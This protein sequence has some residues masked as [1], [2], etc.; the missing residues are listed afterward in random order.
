MF[1]EA[2]KVD[3]SLS[4]VEL[5]KNAQNTISLLKVLFEDFGEAMTWYEQVT[6][7]F[8]ISERFDGNTLFLFNNTNE[9]GDLDESLFGQ[10]IS[11]KYPGWKQEVPKLLSGDDSP[12]TTTVRAFGGSPLTRVRS[13]DFLNL[14]VRLGLILG[15]SLW[16]KCLSFWY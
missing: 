10:H 7:F 8:S 13:P 14:P 16:D 6:E 1:C 9:S 15:G 5:K 4:Y 12:T 11:D 2:V 3:A